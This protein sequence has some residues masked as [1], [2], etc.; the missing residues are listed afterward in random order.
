MET[1][2]QVYGNKLRVRGVGVCIEEGQLLLVNHSGIGAQ[3]FW[4]P[5]GGGIEFSET[6]EDCIER[7]FLEETGLTVEV[8]GFLFACEFIREPLHAIELFFLVKKIGGTLT[9]GA[10]PEMKD[11][12]IIQQVKFLDWSEIGLMDKSRL[13]GIFSKVD[14]VDKIID[15]RGYFKL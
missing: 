10:D 8:C 9:K 2:A 4:S 13:H 1:V 7:E 11:N 6:A 14:K 3:E 5:P 15:L 12:Q